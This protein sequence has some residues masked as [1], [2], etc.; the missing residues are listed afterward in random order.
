MAQARGDVLGDRE[1]LAIFPQGRGVHRVNRRA[2][3]AVL[4]AIGEGGKGGSEQVV[5]LTMLVEEPGDLARV[6][7]EKARELGGYHE[8]DR[9]SVA[10]GNVE[11]SPRERLSHQLRHRVPLERDVGHVHAQAAALEIPA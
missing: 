2:D 6:A 10:L 4:G 1:D 7:H 11:Q 3:L 8:I 5:G 9:R